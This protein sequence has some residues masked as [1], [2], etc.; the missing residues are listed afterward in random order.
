[1]KKI[2]ILLLMSITLLGCSTSHVSDK[3]SDTSS[4]IV[5]KTSDKFRIDGFSYYFNGFSGKLE[6]GWLI[7]FASSME[8]ATNKTYIVN[9]GSEFI[10][11]NKY[12]KV[13]KLSPLDNQ[14]EIQ[15][16]NQN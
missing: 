7:T 10:F 9:E 15:M 14:I 5:L 11:Y 16:I 13:I 2:I 6:E 8:D 4:S 3:T 1:M 12:F